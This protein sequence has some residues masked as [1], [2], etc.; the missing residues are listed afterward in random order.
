MSARLRLY[1]RREPQVIAAYAVLVAVLAWW[2][3]TTPNISLASLTISL[4]AKLPLVMVAIGATIVII[5]K[6]IDLSVGG[7]L[8]LANVIIARGSEATGDATVWI[9]V[10]LAAA[11]LVGAINGV[12]VGLLRLPSLIVTLAM[13][14]LLL[15]IALY[16]L[17]TPGGDVPA[18]FTALSVTLVGPIPLV[19]LLLVLIPVVVWYPIRRSRFGTALYAIGADPAAGYVAGLKVPRITVGAF[20]LS[21]LFAGLGGVLLTTVTGSGDP[22]IG[23]PYTLNSIAAAVLGGVLLSGGRGTIAGAVAGALT[24]SF[25]SNLLFS[26]GISTYWQYV[27][28]GALL[29]AVLALP[30]LTRKLRIRR[31]AASA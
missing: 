22:N 25:I 17:P 21:A 16:I 28:T 5:T 20:V 9:L 24:L 6:G 3:L 23:S 31:E 13:Q 14:S 8:A 2:F 12:L 4:G 15:G 10:A 30:P 29:V 7:T 26:L 18:W 27:V 11:A 19:L 1:L